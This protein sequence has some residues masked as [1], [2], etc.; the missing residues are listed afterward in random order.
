MTTLGR[1]AAMYNACMLVANLGFTRWRDVAKYDA[2]L[3]SKD[4]QISVLYVVS[5]TFKNYENYKNAQL[6]L[7][8]RTQAVGSGVSCGTGEQSDISR[9]CN[10]EGVL[11][12]TMDSMDE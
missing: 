3:F 2:S 7:R 9:V 1:Y 12:R 11:C 5:F 4:G 6:A 8:T 10:R